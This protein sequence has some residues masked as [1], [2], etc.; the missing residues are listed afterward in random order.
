V[1]ATGDTLTILVVDDD[2]VDRMAVRRALLAAGVTADVHEAGDAGQALALLTSREFDCV[3]LDF[4]LPGGDGIGVLRAARAAEVGAP[5]IVLTGQSDVE[6]AAELM[7]E[8]AADYLTKSSLTPE[9]LERSIR[10][11]LRIHQAELEAA[12]A[13]AA[14]EQALTARSRFYATMS[15]E[16]RTPFNAI[17]G[18]TDL[19]LAG[20]YGELNEKQRETLE[21]SQRATRHL[22]ELINDVLDF[23]K[24][25]AGKMDLQLEPVHIPELVDDLLSTVGPLAKERG[26][27]LLMVAT[28]CADRIVTDPKRLRQILMNLLS[29]AIKYGAGSPVTVRCI[30][31]PG[32]FVA[33]EVEDHG[34]GIAPADLPRVFEEYVQ[35]PSA[36]AGGTGLG[37]AISRRLAGLLGGRLEAESTLGAGSIFRLTI[38]NAEAP[39]AADAALGAVDL[40]S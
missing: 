20:I 7:K 27:E 13:N 16:L 6:V 17:L 3:L 4:Q 9:R 40:S 8:G 31:V 5:F 34:A 25:E 12:A 2:H 35:L 23:S 1:S 10:S 14:L 37:L 38:A 33:I 15:H 32:P 28:D 26:C 30:Q 21:R 39:S 24:L 18:Y 11:T 29:N 36:S 22:L 19:I